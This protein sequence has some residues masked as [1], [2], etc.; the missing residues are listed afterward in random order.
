MQLP[1]AFSVPLLPGAS[2]VLAALPSSAFF[3]EDSSV[4]LSPSF[5]NANYVSHVKIRRPFL[6]FILHVCLD[7]L[8][9]HTSVQNHVA[10]ASSAQNNL[11][12][13]SM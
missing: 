2:A 6:L 13:V 5:G 11:V 4:I 10:G 1:V 12:I 8:F 9:A 3:A 7:V